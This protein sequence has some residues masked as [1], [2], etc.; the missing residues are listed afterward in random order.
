MAAGTIAVS[1]PAPP[2]TPRNQG[3]KVRLATVRTPRS[4]SRKSG[5]MRTTAQPA[6]NISA[7]ERL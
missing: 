5:M 3:G 1:A 7:S 2:I 6:K 4:P